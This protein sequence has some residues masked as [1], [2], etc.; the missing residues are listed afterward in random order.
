MIEEYALFSVMVLSGLYGFLKG[1]LLRGVLYFLLSPLLV[2]AV[3][4][5]AVVAMVLMSPVII[6]LYVIFS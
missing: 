6:L 2:Y 3:I 1:G 4:G 5:G